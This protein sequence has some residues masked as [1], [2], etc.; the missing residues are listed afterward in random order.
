MKS[1]VSYVK[2]T[3]NFFSTLITWKGTKNIDIPKADGVVQQLRISHNDG[4]EALRKH[5]H[6]YHNG[7]ILTEEV[8]VSFSRT[9]IFEFRSTVKPQIPGTTIGTIFA[10]T[11]AYICMDYREREIHNSEQF[12]PWIYFRYINI[13][14]I[15]T[16]NEKK[17]DEFLNWL[18]GF[19]LID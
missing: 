8:T 19:T 12:Q 5:L 4:L 16:V 18:N 6:L 9:V 17:F 3:N 13:F 14:L 10:P 2:D 7:S 15:W 11:N 1:R